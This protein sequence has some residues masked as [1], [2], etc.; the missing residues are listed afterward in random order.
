MNIPSDKGLA[1]NQGMS[2]FSSG[3]GNTNI[4]WK[5]DSYMYYNGSDNTW[6]HVHRNLGVI[7]ITANSELLLSRP[8]TVM[9]GRLMSKSGSDPSVSCYSTS[10]GY[11][12]GMWVPSATIYFGTV[13]AAGTPL[14]WKFYS[15]ASSG[16]FVVVGSAWKPGGGPWGDSSDARIKNVIG[17]YQNGL[18]AIRTLRPVK[19]TFIGN[20]TPAGE[21]GKNPPEVDENN[22]KLP[23][24]RKRLSCLTATVRTTR[25]Q[26]QQRN[27]SA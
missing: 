8:T 23:I 16:T 27:V 3:S 20:D 15:E 2:I 24:R 11:A 19:Y 22:E 6:N 5:A 17:D 12:I 1:L 21:L 4:S 18:D 7:G 9:S 26:N 10:G 25:Q 13:D 14:A